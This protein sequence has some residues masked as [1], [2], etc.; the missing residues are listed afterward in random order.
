VINPYHVRVRQKD[1]TKDSYV[2]MSLQL[3]QVDPKSY[4]LDFKSL[5]GEEQDLSLSAGLC[6]LKWNL[7]KIIQLLYLQIFF[8]CRLLVWDTTPWSFLKCVQLL[9]PNWHADKKFHILV[10]R[11]TV[12]SLNFICSDA[13]SLGKMYLSF[14]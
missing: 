14:I 1:R 12:C 11:E 9:S 10:E 4:L 5:S 7:N 13:Y 8:L 3:Y 2:L 6:V